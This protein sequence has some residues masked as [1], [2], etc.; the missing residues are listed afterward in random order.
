MPLIELS[1][2]PQPDLVHNTCIAVSLA[3][4]PW[5]RPKLDPERSRLLLSLL[6]KEKLRGD[7][8]IRWTFPVV[9]SSHPVAG[10]C[11][12]FPSRGMGSSFNI[13]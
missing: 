4:D 11:D 10:N 12:F 8:L 5:A 3:H 2:S 6:Q 9:G 7:E 13:P 1:W